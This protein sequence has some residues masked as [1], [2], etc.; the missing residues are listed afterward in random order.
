MK[1]KQDFLFMKNVIY[2]DYFEIYTDGSK[3][4]NRTG[5]SYIVNGIACKVRLTKYSSVFSAE[6]YAILKSL[7]YI[8]IN[9]NSKF[10]IYSDSLSTIESIKNNKNKNSLNIR[11]SQILSNI[12]K[13]IIVF[14]W[15]PSHIDIKGR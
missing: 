13:K 12:K 10:V 7:K 6:L 14:E 5:C 1:C 11:I 9:N 8:K 4:N 15:V 2:K 3:I